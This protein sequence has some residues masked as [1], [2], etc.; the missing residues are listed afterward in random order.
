MPSHRRPDTHSLADPLPLLLLWQGLLPLTLRHSSRWTHP[1]GHEWDLHRATQRGRRVQRAF[2]AS[3]GR[4]G[5]NGRQAVKWP[6]LRVAEVQPIVLYGS[7]SVG[8][9]RAPMFASIPGIFARTRPVSSS[10]HT[11]VDRRLRPPTLPGSSKAVPDWC[12]ATL[13]LVSLRIG[14]AS[15]T[16]SER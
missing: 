10:T 5:R 9:R 11:A 1:F 15:W 6:P 7:E 4:N 14:T 12:R 2:S 3:H 8:S 13:S 16:P